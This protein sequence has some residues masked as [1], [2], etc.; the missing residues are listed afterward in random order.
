MPPAPTPLSQPLPIRKAEFLRR[1]MILLP[2]LPEVRSGDGRECTSFFRTRTGFLPA[3]LPPSPPSFSA[4]SLSSP[5]NGFSALKMRNLRGTGSGTKRG[6]TWN[7]LLWEV[8]G[9]GAY[10]HFNLQRKKHLPLSEE[11]R[12]LEGEDISSEGEWESLGAKDSPKLWTW[13]QNFQ[14]E[15]STLTCDESD[16]N[17]L[18]CVAI[19]SVCLL[20][21][22]QRTPWLLSLTYFPQTAQPCPKLPAWSP[23]RSLHEAP[24]S[25]Q[26]CWVGGPGTRG[27]FCPPPQGARGS[28]L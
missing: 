2:V 28:A 10:F 6:E 21:L 26:V 4:W 22:F 14:A 13:L 19:P 23:L 1:S 8:A 18:L 12:P 24:G 27:P 7:Q 9:V 5:S 3:S 17:S 16:G 11:V 15:E 20:T 25:R